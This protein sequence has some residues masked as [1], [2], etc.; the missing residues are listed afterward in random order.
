MILLRPPA[1]G[2][3]ANY[4]FLRRDPG[5]RLDERG[6]LQL[7]LHV[8][9]HAEFTLGMDDSR[10]YSD[11]RHSNDRIDARRRKGYQAHANC[12]GSSDDGAG[13]TYILERHNPTQVAQVVVAAPK[14]EGPI[15]V[16]FD[17]SVVPVNDARTQLKDSATSI[18]SKLRQSFSLVKVFSM[19]KHKAIEGMNVTKLELDY[20]INVRKVLYITE[21]VLLLNYVEVIVP[22]IFCC[23][24]SSPVLRSVAP[25]TDFRTPPTSVRAREARRTDPDEA[26]VLGVLQRA[27]YAP[28]LRMGF[29]KWIASLTEFWEAAQVELHGSYSVR[30]VRDYI[31]Y[32][33][34]TGFLR[35]LLVAVLIPW[36]CVII[37]ILVDLIP[38]RPPSEGLHANYLFVVRVFL[39]FLVASIVVNLQFRHS[40]PSAPLSNSRVLI[41]STITAA[42]TTGVLLGLSRA[43]GFPLPFGII[44]VS[45]A[46]V[47]FLLI[48]LASF[49][50]KSSSGSRIMAPCGELTEGLG[51][52][53][54]PR[55]YLSHVFLHLHYTS[56][57]SENTFC[58]ATSDHQNGVAQRHVTHGGP[59]KRR[60]PR[61]GPYECR[62]LQL[63]VHVILYAEYPVNMD[64]TRTN[65][66]RRSSNGGIDARRRKSYQTPA[67][68]EE[69]CECRAY[70]TDFGK[71]QNSSGT[72]IAPKYYPRVHSRHFGAP[73]LQQASTSTRGCS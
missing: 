68:C 13:S 43:V 34:R 22:I 73:L 30:R 29:G 44:T 60:D 21:F 69:S 62:G 47:V 41:T 66:D 14:P 3:D 65:C 50:E 35:A 36:P 67:D 5:D 32:N 40:I 33:Q 59:P 46:W 19:P 28:T 18:G 1:E 23:V 4:L 42:Q 16:P 26:R 27:S 10:A 72:R 20:A 12:E 51:M 7:A 70:S 55:G 38:L 8:L 58:N 64:N 9:L 57:Q 15:V 24:A 54:N 71:F 63:T 48:P 61:S 49:F 53:R 25:I 37:T 11:R 17:T 31:S 2:P 52:S 6:S 56:R 45:P 39:S